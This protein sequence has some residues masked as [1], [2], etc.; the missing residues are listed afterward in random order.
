MF[1]V[2]I[3]MISIGNVPP[4]MT[5]YATLPDKSI[6][7][8]RQISFLIITLFFSFFVSVFSF[9]SIL[10]FLAFSVSFILLP[11]PFSY[12]PAFF[13]SFISFILSFSL[14]FLSFSFF[15]FLSCRSIF[16]L[17]LFNPLLSS[18]IP[19]VCV[20]VSFFL[21][22][23]CSTLALSPF[24]SSTRTRGTGQIYRFRS[25]VSKQ[26]LSFIHKHPNR[27]FCAPIFPVDTEEATYV[28]FGIT[29]PRN[30]RLST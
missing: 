16:P 1:L 18:F 10:F 6:F 20:C 8:V 29:Q 28:T 22:C 15:L 12:F 27:S 19:A 17:T 24:H 4:T 14:F 3:S 25:R 13:L 7:M 2:K 9:S 26:F 23:V 30:G 21:P 5:L 11:F